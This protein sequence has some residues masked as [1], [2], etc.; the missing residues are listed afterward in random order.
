MTENDK[1]NANDEGAAPKVNFVTARVADLVYQN[2]D[3]PDALRPTLMA[4]ALFSR[5]NEGVGLYPSWQSLA[6]ATGR[7]VRQIARDLHDLEAQGFIRRGDQMLTSRIPPWKRPIVYDMAWLSSPVVME[8][9]EEKPAP[10]RHLQPVSTKPYTEAQIERLHQKV[11]SG[12]VP[13]EEELDR[14]PDTDM[15]EIITQGV[16]IYRSEHRDDES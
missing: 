4:M 1:A 14:I 7:S 11:M 2:R 15:L 3:V 12:Y 5:N 10:T 6:W 9:K 16:L 8:Y 13:S